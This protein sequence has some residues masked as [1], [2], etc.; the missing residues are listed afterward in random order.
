L[1]AMKLGEKGLSSSVLVGLTLQ[2]SRFMGLDAAIFPRYCQVPRLTLLSEY[3][4]N[5]R[6]IPLYQHWVKDGSPVLLCS[7]MRHWSKKSS[8]V[9]TTVIGLTNMI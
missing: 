6:N 2:F 4:R 9:A 8:D 7:P 5:H 1:Y 3:Y